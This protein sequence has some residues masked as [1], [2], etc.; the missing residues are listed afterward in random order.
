GAAAGCLLFFFR[1]D[2]GIRGLI[3]TGVQTCAL[4]ISETALTALER[5]NISGRRVQPFFRRACRWGGRLLFTPV[6]LVVCVLLAVAGFAEIGRA[7]CR[8]GVGWGL[9]AAL[10]ARVSPV[11]GEGFR[12]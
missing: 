10:L 12:L 6:A 9:L 4:P 8:E 1:A 7:S 11:D 3:V 5:I 2:D